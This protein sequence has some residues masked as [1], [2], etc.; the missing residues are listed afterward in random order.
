M[1]LHLIRLARA[2]GEAR[3][4]GL[5][6]FRA[7]LLRVA[8]EVE[9]G[10]LYVLLEGELVID[11]PDGSYLHLRRGEAAYLTEP[12]RLIPVDPSVLAVWESG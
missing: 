10:R 8:E 11:L 9:R 4:P 1:K 3:F 2:Q 5:K 12:H 6:P 7:Y